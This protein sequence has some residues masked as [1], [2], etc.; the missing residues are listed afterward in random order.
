M[1]QSVQGKFVECGKFR[2]LVAWHVDAE[3]QRPE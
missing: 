3:L 1:S 2:Q